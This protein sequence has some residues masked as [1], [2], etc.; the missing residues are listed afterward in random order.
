M[1]IVLASVALVLLLGGQV[2]ATHVNEPTSPITGVTLKVFK[3]SE[4]IK[5]PAYMVNCDSSTPP[6]FFP[7]V[8]RVEGYVNAATFPSEHFNLDLRAEFIPRFGVSQT[9]KHDWNNIWGHQN[10]PPHPV[11][12]Q[13]WMPD[14]TIQRPGWKAVTANQYMNVNDVA[15]PLGV[16]ELVLTVTGMESGQVFVD[17]CRWDNI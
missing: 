1:R 12:P 10:I 15:K 14:G 5:D 17:T 8:I 7:D 9:R 16:W 3:Y 4:G 13:V 2:S 11:I 6:K